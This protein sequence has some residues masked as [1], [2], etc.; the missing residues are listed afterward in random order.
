MLDLKAKICSCASLQFTTSELDAIKFLKQ[1]FFVVD[2]K[3]K[4]FL[5]FL[6]EKKLQQVFDNVYIIKPLQLKP[7]TQVLQTYQNQLQIITS[8]IEATAHVEN[9]TSPKVDLGNLSQTTDNTTGVSMLVTIESGSSILLSHYKIDQNNTKT[10]IDKYRILQD[11]S[12]S[13]ANS[14]DSELL[15]MITELP[16]YLLYTAQLIDNGIL[17]NWYIKV[18]SRFYMYK[19]YTFDFTIRTFQVYIEGTNLQASAKYYQTSFPPELIKTLH[20]MVFFVA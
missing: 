15:S 19:A 12:S 13:K 18:G 10:L 14:Q 2:L 3:K 20:N 11:T 1:G 16:A 8:Q 4:V 5:S 7:P 17:I 6:D 9:T